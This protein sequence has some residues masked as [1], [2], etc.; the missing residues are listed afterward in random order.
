MENCP[1][2]LSNPR[3][4]TESG[5]FRTEIGNAEYSSITTDGNH[6]VNENSTDFERAGK[7][8]VFGLAPLAGSWQKFGGQWRCF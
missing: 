2:M 6:A 5:M 7:R 1:T 8:L 4:I 3:A